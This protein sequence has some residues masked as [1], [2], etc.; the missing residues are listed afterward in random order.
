MGSFN[1]DKRHGLGHVLKPLVG[2]K[3]TYQRIPHIGK[4]IFSDF[5]L[6][7][8]VLLVTHQYIPHIGN[9]AGP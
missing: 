9:I 7:I 5:G 8:K 6:V 1:S 2:Y 3:S 4:G